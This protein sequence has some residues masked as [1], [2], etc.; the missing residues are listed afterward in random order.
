MIRRAICALVVFAVAVGFVTADEFM[1]QITRVDGNKITYQKYS[2][3]EKDGDAVTIEVASDAKVAEGKRGSG[4]RPYVAGD[5]VEGG[6]K[7]KIF[8]T[9]PG[10]K[11]VTAYMATGDGNKTVKQVLVLRNKK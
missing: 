6:L 10:D 2:K 8:P 9:A 1:A 4:A 11:G 3:G 7:N 5:D